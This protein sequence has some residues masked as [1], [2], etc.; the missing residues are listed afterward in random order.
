M[1]LPRPLARMAVRAAAALIILCAAPLQHGPWGA[2]GQEAT[3]SATPTSLAEVTAA[4]ESFIADPSLPTQQSV[5][6]WWTW[7]GGSSRN[8]PPAAPV[9]DASAAGYDV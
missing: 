3:T 6:V 7:I 4:G 9:Y 1:G 8:Y 2:L 5:Y